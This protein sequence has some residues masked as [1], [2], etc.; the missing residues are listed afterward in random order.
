MSGRIFELP[1][2][3]S[4]Q[5]SVAEA[6]VYQQSWPEDDLQGYLWDAKVSL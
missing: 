6:Q 2:D 1:E 5:D 3:S 4:L